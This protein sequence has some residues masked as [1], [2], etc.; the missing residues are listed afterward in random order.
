[1]AFESAS[2]EDISAEKK[3]ELINS[4]PPAFSLAKIFLPEP[5]RPISQEAPEA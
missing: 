5:P 4:V 2:G 1:L 3:D